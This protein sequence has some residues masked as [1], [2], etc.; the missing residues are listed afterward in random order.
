FSSQVDFAFF[1]IEDVAPHALQNRDRQE[2]GVIAG[3]VVVS[4]FTMFRECPQSRGVIAEQTHRTGIDAQV[5]HLELVD[6]ALV[7]GYLRSKK[8]LA[9][10]GLGLAGVALRSVQR[11]QIIEAIG[12][13]E[14]LRA[15]TCLA[16]FQGLPVKG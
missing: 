13:S 15:E 11:S 12:E 6:W 9:V 1:L 5:L 8:G 14:V 16:N 3:P 10:Q 7:V 4:A 2:Q